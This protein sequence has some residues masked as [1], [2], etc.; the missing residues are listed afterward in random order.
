[1]EKSFKT[2]FLMLTRLNQRIKAAERMLNIIENIRRKHNLTK[3]GALGSWI[4]KWLFCKGD[5]NGPEIID[6]AKKVIIAV[7]NIIINFIS[8]MD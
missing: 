7:G 8:L 1:M 5:G 6:Q 2:R 3:C 4:L